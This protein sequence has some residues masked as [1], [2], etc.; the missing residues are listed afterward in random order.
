[1]DMRMDMSKKKDNTQYIM[2]ALELLESGM[3]EREIESRFQREGKNVSEYL[4]LAQALIRERVTDLPSDSLLPRILAD[5]PIV[6]ESQQAAARAAATG[7][8]MPDK[9]T[10][11]NSP[12]IAPSHPPVGKLVAVL[13]PYWRYLVPMVGVVVLLVIIHFQTPTNSLPGTPTSGVVSDVS[14]NSSFSSE[15]APGPSGP[16]AAKALQFAR[17]A[18]ETVSPNQ[19]V[20]ALISQVTN[21][22]QAYDAED[23]DVTNTHFDTEQ[24]LPAVAQPYETIQ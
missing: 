20:E 21:E 7:I 13:S 15:T 11:I 10:V 5:I 18:V 4:R 6:S 22:A 2:D 8:R 1:M 3:S 14:T 17:T 23:T 16:P 24:Y 19:V 9:A 12:D